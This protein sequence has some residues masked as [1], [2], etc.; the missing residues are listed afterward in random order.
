MGIANLTPLDNLSEQVAN[1]TDERHLVWVTGGLGSGRTELARRIQQHASDAVVVEL[2]PLAEA[3]APLHG[4]LQAASWLASREARAAAASETGTILE[5]A[6]RVGQALASEGKLLLLLV[7]ASWQLGPEPSEEPDQHFQAEK[8]R[9][10]L[11]GFAQADDLRVVLFTSR[12]FS[13]SAL[14]LEPDSQY[15]LPSLHANAEVLNDDSFWGN[16]ASA[17]RAVSRELSTTSATLSPLELRL[18]VGVAALGAHTQQIRKAWRSPDCVRNLA[19]LLRDALALPAN[20]QVRRPLFRFALAR[21]SLPKSFLSTFAE[22]PPEHLPLFTSC[23]GYGDSDIR[24]TET[25]RLTLLDSLAELNRAEATPAHAALAAHHKQLDGALAPQDAVSERA[26]HWLEKAHHLAHGGAATQAEWLGL[27]LKSREF[28]L[29]RARSLSIERQDYSGAAAVYERYVAL[30][31]KDAYGWHY[32][33]FNLDKANEKLDRALECYRKAVDLDQGNPW[34]NSRQVTFL[35]RRSR[36]SEAEVEWKNALQRVDPDGRRVLSSPWL[37]MH[38]HR[39]VAQSWMDF[40]ETEAASAALDAIPTSTL[41]S[42]EPL[43]QLAKRIEDAKEALDL[44]D[45]VYPRYIDAAARWLEPLV[46]PREHNGKHLKDWYPGRVLSYE[47]EKVRILFATRDKARLIVNSVPAADWA[48]VGWC[49]SPEEAVP[50]FVE[51]G[52]YGDSDMR[53]LPLPSPLRTQAQ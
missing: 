40:G 9:E 18:S 38:F 13:P 28:L 27:E 37:A 35:I 47:N 49:S 32:L 14:S 42:L 1:A 45:S 19:Q 51:I 3:D 20:Q 26:S 29:D 22:A 24:I 48:K 46:L 5:R 30:A 21:K 15:P 11:Q 7:P 50:Y 53:I 43:R 33:G 52:L 2:V 8:A 12:D 23:I 16:Y 41:L 44:G 36:V 34:W 10:L 31:P 17:A 4:L 6:K 39:W 25:V